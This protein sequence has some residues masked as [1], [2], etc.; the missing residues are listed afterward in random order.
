MSQQVLRLSVLRLIA[1]LALFGCGKADEKAPAAK[2]EVVAQS[3]RETELRSKNFAAIPQN[4]ILKVDLDKDGFEIPSSAQLR[5][6][7]AAS[8]NLTGADIASAF[9]KGAEPESISAAASDDFD[10]DLDGSTE[11]YSQYMNDLNQYSANNSSSGRGRFWPSFFGRDATTA[12]G[13]FN[14]GNAGGGMGGAQN[15][16]G[17]QEP[18]NYQ[19]AGQNQQQGMQGYYYGQSLYR[20]RFLDTDG[21]PW[22]FGPKQ[23]SDNAGS[24]YYQFAPQGSGYYNSPEYRGTLTSPYG[25]SGNG[26]YDLA[27]GGAYQGGYSSSYN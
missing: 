11:S 7:F 4:V 10:S 25:A 27:G 3:A 20:P 16:T 15:G 2:P 22:H 23:V 1:A 18:Q 26:Q 24:R 5:Y 19:G 9:D 14:R 21:L 8:E 6:A 12:N 13:W 17:F